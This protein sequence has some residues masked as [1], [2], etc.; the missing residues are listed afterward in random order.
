MGLAFVSFIAPMAEELPSAIASYRYLSPVEGPFDS[1]EQQ[2][3]FAYRNELA[4]QR[5][6]FERSRT[7]AGGAASELRSQGELNREIDRI[8]RLLMR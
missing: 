3:A 6:L 5:R 4:A 8:D 1:L 2:K 7:P